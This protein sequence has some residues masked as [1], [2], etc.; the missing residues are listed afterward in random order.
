MKVSRFI[1]NALF[2][3]YV[4]ILW[5]E[6]THHAVVIDPGMMYDHERDQLAKFIGDNRLEVQRLLLTH[7]HVDHAFSARWVADRYHVPVEGSALDADYL[8]NMPTQAMYFHLSE[9]PA[10]LQIDHGLNDGD[11]IMV[12]DEEIQVLA[13]PGHSPGGLAFYL[14]ESQLIVSGDSIFQGS[15][16]RT[17][18]PGCNH[19][20]LLAAIHEKILTLPD[21]VL[22]CP[23]HGPLTTVADER[24][25]NPFLD[26]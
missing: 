9:V 22:I 14:P 1:A 8:Q 24:V 18:L 11:T 25:H 17:D 19:Q 4:Y 10:P 7:G 26:Y 20:T 23:G 16:G 13:C 2:G 5:N 12:D 3:E 15:I 21:E 6:T